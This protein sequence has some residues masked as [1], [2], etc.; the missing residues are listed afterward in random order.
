MQI[1]D[2]PC[3][4]LPLHRVVCIPCYYGARLEFLLQYVLLA[5][6]FLASWLHADVAAYAMDIATRVFAEFNES[7]VASFNQR[8][9]LTLA[10]L[11]T[12]QLHHR[13]D[14]AFSLVFTRPD[15][16]VDALLVG[17]SHN[18]TLDYYIG[19]DETPSEIYRLQYVSWSWAKALAE[20]TE[21]S[22]GRP[23][24]YIPYSVGTQTAL[25]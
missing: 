12:L 4:L 16:K 9:A 11:V 18:R 17:P 2:Q 14:I 6:Q 24:I 21:F 5:R 10:R 23:C 13:D 19:V 7:V 20:I 1:Q 3:V 15:G 8:A 22:Q 25:I